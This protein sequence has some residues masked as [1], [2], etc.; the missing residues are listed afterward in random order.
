MPIVSKMDGTQ[1]R[2]RCGINEENSRSSGVPVYEGWMATSYVL[3][4]SL[5][6]RCGLRRPWTR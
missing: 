4:M 2:A 6:V 3:T 1:R 5:A